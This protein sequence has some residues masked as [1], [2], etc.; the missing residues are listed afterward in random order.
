MGLWDTLIGVGGDI[1]SAYIGGQTAGKAADAQV[2]ALN[3]GTQISQEAIARARKDLLAAGNPGIEDI[4]SGYQ[5]SVNVLQEKGPAEQKA[6]AL[7]GALGPELQQQAQN[8]FNLS[9]GQ[10]YLRDQQQEALLNNAS[11]IGGIGGGRVRSA[12]QEQAYGNAAQNQQQY[13]QNIMSLIN[14]ESTRATNIANQLSGGG[15][16]L[17]TYRSGLGANLANVA[18]GGASQQIPLYSSAGKAQSAGI[19]GQGS[20]VQQGIGNISNTLGTIYATP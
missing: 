13:F 1:A 15:Q 16:Q 2:S 3:K 10:Q 7:S 17:A 14:P 9:P 12:L 8:E 6:L 5:G 20:A 19:L 11:A 18:F 4:I